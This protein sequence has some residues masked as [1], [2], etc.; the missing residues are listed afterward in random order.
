MKK[1][2]FFLLIVFVLIGCK[3]I[4]EANENYKACIQDSE[5]VQEVQ[6]AQAV[7]SAV[8]KSAGSGLPS[9]PIVDALAV[10]LSNVVAFA[11]G[12]YQGKKRRI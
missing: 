6:K 12:S 2:L 8:I 10:L 9:S 3:T 1:V 5:C 11:V 4:K 7:S